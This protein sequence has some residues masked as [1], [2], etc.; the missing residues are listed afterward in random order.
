MG[1]P[2]VGAERRGKVSAAERE[3]LLKNSGKVLTNGGESGIIFT[4]KQRG[5]KYGKHC[6]DWGLDPSNADDREKMDEIVDDIVSNAS[7]RRIGA[8]NGQDKE[9]IFYIKGDDVVITKQ[10]NEFITILKGGI[11]DGWVKNAR[12][13][14]IC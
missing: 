9:C 12:R 7:E 8:F 10:N 5:K 4:N 2:K 3:E 11:E 6:P 14:Q 1:V 13:L